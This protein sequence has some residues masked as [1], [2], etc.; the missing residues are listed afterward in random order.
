MHIL[1]KH[2]KLSKQININ[3]IAKNLLEETLH[4]SPP[5]FYSILNIMHPMEKTREI[6][7]FDPSMK[8]GDA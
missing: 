7:E 3:E 6:E 8:Q 5:P 1:S 4:K 2:R